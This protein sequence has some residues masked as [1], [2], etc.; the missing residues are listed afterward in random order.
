MSESD[1]LAALP[2][3][4]KW[5]A[6]LGYTLTAEERM[7][8]HMNLTMEALSIQGSLDEAMALLSTVPQ[9]IGWRVR[10]IWNGE[11]GML[12]ETMLPRVFASFS[13]AKSEASNVQRMFVGG[14]EL[15]VFT[16]TD[17]YR[18]TDSHVKIYRR[19][20]GTK[21]LSY[22]ILFDAPLLTTDKFEPVEIKIGDILTAPDGFFSMSDAI[23]PVFEL[24][25]SDKL[26]IVLANG[27]ALRGLEQ[28]FAVSQ[29]E[30][31]DELIENSPYSERIALTGYRGYRGTANERLKALRLALISP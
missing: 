18:I 8:W 9:P 27:K 1:S 30:V 31:V 7:H 25:G 11:E 16:E 14:N 15:E 4:E 26:A 6:K 2:G 23:M 22:K 12:I 5:L 3:I 28:R 19:K 20:A 21:D 29:T 13:V 10:I 17:R 24:Y